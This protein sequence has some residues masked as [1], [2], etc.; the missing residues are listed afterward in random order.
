VATRWARLWFSFE[1]DERREVPRRLHEL[2]MAAQQLGFDMETAMV[3]DHRPEGEW[4]DQPDG[5]RAYGPP[6]S[7]H[8]S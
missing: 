2:T 4:E 7:E 5:S 1:T 8:D 6:L 3:Q